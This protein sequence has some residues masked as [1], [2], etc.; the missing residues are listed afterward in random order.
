MLS[1][2]PNRRAGKR[3]RGKEGGGKGRRGRKGKGGTERR[4]YKRGQL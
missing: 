3:K 2:A 1:S 4:G